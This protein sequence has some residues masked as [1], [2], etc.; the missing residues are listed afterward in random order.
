[1]KLG[2]GLFLLDPVRLLG[3]IRGF[4]FDLWD[5]LAVDWFAEASFISDSGMRASILS[6]TLLAWA[7]LAAG[8]SPSLPAFSARATAGVAQRPGSTHAR[9]AVRHGLV[10]L[11]AQEETVV[12][13]AEVVAMDPKKELMRILCPGVGLKEAADPAKRPEVTELL[14]KMECQNPTEN[15]A[16]SDLLNG[17]WEILF[18]GGYGSGLVDSPTRELALLAYT[19]GY[20]P[21]LLAN[22]ADKLPGPLANLLEVDDMQLVINPD[23]P[24]TEASLRISAL[25]AGSQ[26]VKVFGNLVAESD[27][28]LKETVSKG[29]AFDRTF[30]LPLKY[31]RQ[32]LVTYVDEDLLVSVSTR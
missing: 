26:R 2:S 20:R 22:W 6:L 12:S 11:R 4:V 17:A 28:R 9:P 30:D 32:L 10:S 16:T 29:E 1:L 25:N 7:P 19:G 13:E 24:R 8:F 21:G 5:P 15:P 23:E 3:L 18:S 14:R 27:M 31:E